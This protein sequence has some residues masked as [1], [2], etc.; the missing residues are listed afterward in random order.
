VVATAERPGDDCPAFGWREKT[1]VR[2][3]QVHP[4]EAAA[5]PEWSAY[6]GHYRS[7]DP[8]IGSRR[9]SLR[10]GALWLDGG[11][12]LVPTGDGRF[13][14]RNEPTSPEWVAFADVVGG[15]AMR[16]LVSGYSLVRIS[17]TADPTFG[18]SAQAAD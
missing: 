12:P 7:E 13:W 8:W 5:P 11:I 15:R 18:R 17:E 1:F 14:L 2:E 3:G 10:G 9:V 6:P 16:L 4:V